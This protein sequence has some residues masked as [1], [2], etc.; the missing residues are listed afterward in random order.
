LKNVLQLEE[1][2]KNNEG[3]FGLLN[4]D[5]SGDFLA[6]VKLV[7]ASEDPEIKPEITVKA[8]PPAPA[9]VEKEKKEKTKAKV[10]NRFHD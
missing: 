1:I 6:K 9:K 5:I 3:V 4:K 7:D 2:F 8:N 10:T